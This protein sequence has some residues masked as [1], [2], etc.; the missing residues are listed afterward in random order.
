MSMTRVFS[1][2]DFEEAFSYAMAWTVDEA[3]PEC[4]CQYGG[5]G[6]E[7]RPESRTVVVRPE[8]RSTVPL[9][10]VHGVPGLFERLYGKPRRLARVRRFLG[11]R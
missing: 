6:I 11:L 5:G 2:D 10:P 9:C 1:E 4:M 3:N 8:I 7:H